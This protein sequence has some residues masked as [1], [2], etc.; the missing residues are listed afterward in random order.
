MTKLKQTQYQLYN[1]WC[2]TENPDLLLKFINTFDDYINM[3]IKNINENDKQDLYQQIMLNIITACSTYKNTKPKSNIIQYI[4]STIHY[5]TCRY[6]IEYDHQSQIFFTED[7]IFLANMGPIED[8]DFIYENDIKDILGSI[9]F[10]LLEKEVLEYY[11]NGINKF[12][13]IAKITHIDRFKVAE[14]YYSAVN[15]II[16][17]FGMKKNQEMLENAS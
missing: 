11:L 2:K 13:D 9:D 7:N 4:F 3:K 10:T 8:S 17:Y 5:T 6:F 14:N 1:K 16:D 12:I 15:K